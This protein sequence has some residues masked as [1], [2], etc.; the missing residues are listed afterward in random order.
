MNEVLA[1]AIFLFNEKSKQLKIDCI[2]QAIIDLKAE[3]HIEDT[4][5]LFDILIDEARQDYENSLL[6]SWE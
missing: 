4:A 1:R 2:R 3:R 6:R 5:R